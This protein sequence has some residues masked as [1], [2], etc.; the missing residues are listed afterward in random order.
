[1]KTRKQIRISINNLIDQHGDTF[2]KCKGCPICVEIHQLQESLIRDPEQK[3]QH[4]LSKGQDMTKSEITMLLE[5]GMTAAT[6]R[7]Y[8]KMDNGTFQ[9]TLHNWGLSKRNRKDEDD[10]GKLEMTIEEF[11]D[12]RYVQKLPFTKIAE[13]KGVKDPTIHNWKNARESQI[14]LRLK[15]LNLPTTEE[16]KLPKTKYTS[17]ENNAKSDEYERLISA[18]RN[19]LNAYHSQLEEKDDQIRS[20]H[21]QRELFKKEMSENNDYILSLQNK[22][23]DLENLHAACEDVE[24]E[25]ASLKEENTVMKKRIEELEHAPLPVLLQ[26]DC[27]D[28]VNRLT[29]ENLAMR[30][31][32]RLWM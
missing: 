16:K 14:N 22:V 21:H 18:L 25:L 9:N 5:N 8:M 24:N 20:L 26:C 23:Q 10:M 28:K 32:L 2:E 3:Y 7:K 29:E 30:Q 4:I 6:I 19:D 12:L 15:A 17:N 27:E 11:V 1:M 13:L 31:L